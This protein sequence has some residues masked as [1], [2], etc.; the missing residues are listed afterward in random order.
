M[1]FFKSLQGK[2]IWSHIQWEITKEIHVR[3]QQAAYETHTGPV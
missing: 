3:T 2:R 1:A